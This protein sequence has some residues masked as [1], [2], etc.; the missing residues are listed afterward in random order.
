MVD[1]VVALAKTTKITLGDL[2]VQQAL[3]EQ[4]KALLEQVIQLILCEG[5][6]FLIS[7]HT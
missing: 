7:L 4:V 1:V 3:L 2:G 6:S 5:E